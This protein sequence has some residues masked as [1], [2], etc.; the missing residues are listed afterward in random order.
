[1]LQWRTVDHDDALHL[2]GR[3]L[4]LAEA[5]GVAHVQAYATPAQK[6]GLVSLGFRARRS[7]VELMCWPAGL[8][9]T[10]SFAF[11]GYDSDFGL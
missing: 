9:E 7:L 8:V 2:F 4:Y 1:M 10:D 5:Y 3:V 6:A 11:T